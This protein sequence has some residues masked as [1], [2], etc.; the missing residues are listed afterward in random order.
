MT[1]FSFRLSED[2]SLAAYL[3]LIADCSLAIQGSTDGRGM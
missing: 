2:T 3:G 1:I